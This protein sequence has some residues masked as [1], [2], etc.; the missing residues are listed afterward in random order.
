MDLG[1]QRA[2]IEPELTEAVERVVSRGDFILGCE[3]AVFESEFAA[4]CDVAHAVG[5]DS[6]TSGLELALL[7]L[8]VGPGDEVITA[9]NTFVATAL[10]I[11]HS[12]A[13]PVLVDVD[14]VTYNID[15]ELI[16]AAISPQTKAIVPVH[17]YGHPA[18]MDPILDVARQHG[19][20][21]LEDASQAHGARY[22]GGRVGSM[23]DAAVFS[24]YPSKNL[25]ALGD[26]GVVV[27]DDEDLATQLAKMRNYGSTDKYRHDF[28]GYNRRLD[29]IHASVLLAKLPYLDDWNSRRRDHAATY[30]SALSRFDDRLKLPSAAAYA[31]P[32]YYVYVIEVDERD[33]LR[34]HMDDAG[35]STIIHYPTPIHL[36]PAYADLGLEPGTFPVTESAARRILSL[37]MYPELGERET[38]AVIAATSEFLEDLENVGSD[39]T[40]NP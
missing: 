5:V 31:E 16:E 8:G 28:R 9:A 3:V 39:Q 34:A 18:D 13:K 15:V 32:V 7:A 33:A 12:G 17:L 37:P 22:K 35:I 11:S 27:T 2:S 40:A 14:P 20:K 24:L 19:L 30:E 23:G 21:V 25:G 26:A 38:S 4:Y 6:G 1:A 36:Q 29:T 10:A